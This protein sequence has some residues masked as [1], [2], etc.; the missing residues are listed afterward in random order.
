MPDLINTLAAEWTQILKA[1]L[2][3]LV[4]GFPRGVLLNVGI[5]ML[6]KTCQYDGQVSTNLRPYS[7]PLEVDVI[8]IS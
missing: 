3:T 7:V 8:N 4:K 1:M 2:Q 5:G 6:K